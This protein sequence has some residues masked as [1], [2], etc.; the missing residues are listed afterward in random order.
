MTAQI[1]D[2]AFMRCALAQAQLAFDANEVPVGAVVV[3]DG[4][5]I[6]AGYNAPVANNDPCAHAEVQ[7]IRAAA[8]Y[9]G[10]YRLDGCTLYVTLEP[11]TMCSG[12]LRNARIAR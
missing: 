12:A 10:N 2:Q 3:K 4:Q 7:A 9:L 8:A 1:T 5:V 6:G 11:C